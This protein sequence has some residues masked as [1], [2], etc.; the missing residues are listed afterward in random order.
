LRNGGGGDSKSGGILDV[1]CRVARTIRKHPLGGGL[2]KDQTEAQLVARFRAGDGEAFAELLR[3]CERALRERVRLRLARSV[4]RR[5][6]VSDVVQEAEMAAYEDR[7]SFE[8]RGEGAF[9]RWMLGIVDKKVLMAVRTHEGAAKRDVRQ[10]LTR[11]RR[12]DTGLL[13]GRSPTPSQVAIA[14][15]LAALAREAMRA[16]PEDYR[17]VLRLIREEQ[18]P[19]EEVANRMGRTVVATKKL[20]ARALARFE[21]ELTRRRGEGLD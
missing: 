12:P 18:L 8:D 6:S 5:V 14:G 21:E 20:S 10:E 15:E 3:R 11:S 9:G 2:L 1:R 16:L 4:R 13:R 19:V 17:E 7:A